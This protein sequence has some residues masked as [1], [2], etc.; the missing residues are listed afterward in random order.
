M[1]AI[2]DS[3]G[4]NISSIIFAFERI[5]VNAKLTSAKDE[6]LRASH[7]ILPGVGSACDAMKKIQEFDL[8]KTISNLTQPVLG[9][10]LG[11]QILYDFSKEGDV[12]CLKIVSGIID[13]LPNAPNITIPHMGWNTLKI[14]KESPLFKEID[15][16]SYVYFVHTYIAPLTENTIVISEYGQEFTAACQKDNF[17]GMQFHPERSGKVGA[18]ILKNFLEL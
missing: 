14:N 11:M 6:I 12:E 7:V 5:G 8:K 3:G 15:D 10:C 9:I 18:K 17:F 2:L 1:I 13:S 4:A 16:N